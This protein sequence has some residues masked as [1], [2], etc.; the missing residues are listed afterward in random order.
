MRTTELPLIQK[1][2]L[3]KF[4]GGMNLYIPTVNFCG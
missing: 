3:Q 2:M 1:A 4:L